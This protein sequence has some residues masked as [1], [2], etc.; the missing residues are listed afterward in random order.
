MVLALAVLESVAFQDF[1][2]G[3]LVLDGDGG[4]QAPADVGEIQ[5]DRGVAGV[6]GDE[7][8][9]VHK[10]ADRFHGEKTSS[11]QHLRQGGAL[12]QQ[13]IPAEPEETGFGVAW[14][15]FHQICGGGRGYSRSYLNFGEEKAIIFDEIR[16]NLSPPLRAP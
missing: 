12:Y 15:R 7:A 10:P 16:R 2:E 6:S 13:K 9:L 3:E 8:T 5:L 11:S 4:L 14:R 1:E